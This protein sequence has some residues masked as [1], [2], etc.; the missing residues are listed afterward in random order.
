LD[1]SSNLWD[2]ENQ[3]GENEECLRKIASE[4]V[5]FKMNDPSASFCNRRP[6]HWKLDEWDNHYEPKEE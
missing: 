2:Q 3:N 1:V 4:G 6:F 5:L